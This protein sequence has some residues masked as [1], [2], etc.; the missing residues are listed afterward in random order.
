MANYT[1]LEALVSTWSPRSVPF[2]DEE[3][4]ES[5]DGPIYVADK[6]MM[7]KKRGPRR[8]ARYAIEMDRVKLGCFKRTNVNSESVDDRHHIRCLKCHKVSHNRRRCE[9][10]VRR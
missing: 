10:N 6:A 9:D 8:H 7:S 3:Q 1:T 5:Y 4:L 2:L